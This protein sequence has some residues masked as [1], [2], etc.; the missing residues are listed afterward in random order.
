MSNPPQRGPSQMGPGGRVPI[1]QHFQGKNLEQVRE[2]ALDVNFPERLERPALAERAAAAFHEAYERLA[3]TF[4]YRT[5]EASAVPWADVPESNRQLMIA[6]VTELI[7]DGVIRVRQPQPEPGDYNPPPID[8]TP[9][10][11][12][13]SR[14]PK[15]R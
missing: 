7:E 2:D 8:P 10:S 9:P 11:H 4:S 14:S 15:D 5:R 1:D 6:V 13:P 12:R 3:P